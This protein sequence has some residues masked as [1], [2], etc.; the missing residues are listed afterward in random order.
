MDARIRHG[1]YATALRSSAMDH[2][3]ALLALLLVSSALAGCISDPDAGGNDEFDS[4]ALQDL[5]DENLQDFMNNTSI[6]VNNHFYNNT[7]VVN[8][9]NSVSNVNGSGTGYGSMMHM[10]TVDW[11]DEYH[12]DYDI[13]NHTL[14]TIDNSSNLSSF[15]GNLTFGPWGYNGQQ[16][17][18]Q[19]TCA[20]VYMTAQGYY[21]D[22]Y[23]WN[24]WL[25]D[26][27]GYSGSEL[28]VANSIRAK[29]SNQYGQYAYRGQCT[30]HDS[31]GE[32]ANYP[33]MADFYY[34]K[35]IE[36]FEIDTA[37]GEVFLILSW[38]S[39]MMIEFVCSDGWSSSRY[40][41][42]YSG[43]VGGQADCVMTGI[44]SYWRWDIAHEVI[45]INDQQYAFPY[46]DYN[47]N[48]ANTFA[49]YY[50]IHP[51]IVEEV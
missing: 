11:S 35:D 6:T 23:Y 8:S 5:I 4:E 48:V 37:E 15:G 17:Y 49:V 32:A 31:E 1:V 13:L 18:V 46:I 51:A 33:G 41:H 44:N 38:P 39:S 30:Q 40:S 22:D 10:F 3:A 24:D 42:D 7:T 50:E 43:Y 14:Q 20:E 2:K 12:L 28:S 19:P 16:V 34:D 21:D 29:V 9:D 47:T 36:L 45:Y 26:R 27:Y 25:V